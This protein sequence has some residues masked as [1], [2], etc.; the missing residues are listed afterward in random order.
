[1]NKNLMLILGALAISGGAYYL[2]SRKNKADE[3][4]LERLSIVPPA[5]PTTI[6]QYTTNGYSA[7]A[8]IG[9]LTGKK[10]GGA[11]AGAFRNIGKR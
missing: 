1:M 6:P 2:I 8:G 9:K 7:A 5:E 10:T 3:A 11:A 4:A